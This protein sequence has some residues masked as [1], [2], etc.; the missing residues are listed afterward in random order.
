MFKCCQQAQIRHNSPMTQYQPISYSTHAQQRWK[1]YTNYQ[2]AAKDSVAA[3]VQQEMVRACMHLPIAFIE[4]KSTDGATSFLPVAI[5]G[6]ETEQNLLVAPDG[7]WLAPYIPAAYRGY[8]FAL[9]NTEQN[10]QVLCMLADSPL[11][12]AADQAAAHPD[13]QAFFDADKQPSTAI[14]EVMEFLQQV[15]RNRHQTQRACAALQSHG[16]FTPW[17]LVIKAGE[18]QQVLK[19]LFRVDEGKLAELDGAALQNLQQVGAMS[20]VYCQLLS[21][22]HVQMLGKL[23]QA[24][25]QSQQ[26]NPASN[27]PTTA[28]G[29]LDLEF[30]HQGGTLSF[31]S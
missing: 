7:R 2:F 1:R 31:G 26:A 24:R 25:T 30:L 28:K 17:P 27:L 20:M 18:T 11:L 4:Q 10:Q 29:E 13:S 15:Q 21:M 8:P 5:Q 19:G 23:A 9:A 12:I 22:Q 14:K 3:L 16:L 6:L